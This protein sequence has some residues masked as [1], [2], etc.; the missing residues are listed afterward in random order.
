MIVRMS[1]VVV[2]GPK[3]LLMD[4]LGKIHELGILHIDK[5]ITSENA[6]GFEP[7]LKATMPDEKTLSLRLILEELKN[8][9]DR[10]LELLPKVTIRESFLNPAAAVTF[11]SETIDRHLTLCRGLRNRQDVIASEMNSFKDIKEFIIAAAELLPTE[12]PGPGLSF[13]AVKITD[14]DMATSLE[15]TLGRE[16]GGR[17][18]MVTS[19]MSD[20]TLLGV[21]TTEKELLDKLETML[22][23]SNVK[24]HSFPAGFANLSLHEQVRTAQR[25]ITELEV[26]NQQI[27]K[28][29]YD[30]A[31][32]WSGAYLELRRWLAQKLSVI[33]ASA[34]LY[35]TDLCFFLFGWLP[36]RDLTLLT[37]RLVTNF[38]GRVVVE[39]KAIHEHELENVPTSLKNPPYLQPFELFARLLPVPAYS[40][41]DLTPFIGIFFPLFFG[42][43]LGDIGYGL[44][45]LPLS[46]T[47]EK[48]FKDRKN[49]RDAARILF[50]SSLYTIVFGVLFGEFFGNIGS[51]FLGLKPL[52]FDRHQSLMPMLYFALAMGIVHI[53]IGLLLGLLS[54]LRKKLR[55]EAL[56][57]FLSMLLIIALA[58]IAIL[59]FTDSFRIVPIPL[60]MVI[61]AIIPLLII[62]G[63][64]LAP[65]E[66][67]KH[68]G[69]IISYARI[70]AIGLTSVL[71]AYVANHLAGMT[72][73]IWL[74]I[75]VAIILH[76]FNIMLG[77]FAPTIHALRLHYVEF[78]SKF[79]EPGGREFKPLGKK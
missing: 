66:V 41:F 75:F 31:I 45:L 52:F 28:K 34:S 49:I 71:L 29:L 19:P 42:M 30:F 61:G 8:K 63:G 36:S 22:K 57:K 20:G 74:G 60:L 64:L 47:V 24:Q 70:M 65:L 44:I 56:F 18:E 39:E 4:V 26:E 59:L 77:V 48:I 73:S 76:G 72:G 32:S 11:L 68:F 2:I 23:A 78:F 53:L 33:Q 15:E 1:K 14:R 43:M 69:N 21:I 46:L 10:L 67:L 17:F 16:I 37:E 62:S 50:I 38:G 13:L 25:K 3:E 35:E 79:M 7:L 58:S 6:A 9:M 12:E 55:K 51:R 54:A 27:N 40:S 5:S